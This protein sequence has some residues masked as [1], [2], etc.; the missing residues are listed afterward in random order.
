MHTRLPIL[1]SFRRC[2]YAMRARLAL[3]ASGQAVEL[4]EVVLRDKP[5]ALRVISPKATV[6]VLQL[7]D[8]RVLEES[9]DIMRWALGCSDPEGW[10]PEPMRAS[11][12]DGLIARNDREFKPW[13]DRYK[14]ADRYPERS[15]SDYRAEG[16][17]FLT[18]LEQ[19]LSARAALAGAGWGLADA[20]I[21][22]F[23]RQF[24]LVD[25]PWF[26]QAPYP[27][28]RHWLDQGIASR[29]FQSIM[30]KYPPWR[31]GDAPTLFAPV[32]KG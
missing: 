8:G 25:R 2:P 9:L 27:A 15:A 7:A 17:R 23:V 20:A 13:L 11:E 22:P 4:R 24:A 16:E 32:H 5:E 1:Y 30:T 19:R 14:Y 12:V 21:L 18:G 3:A 10:L 26:D 6:P 28:L 31:E 29:R